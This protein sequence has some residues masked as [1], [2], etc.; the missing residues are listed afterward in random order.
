VLVSVLFTLYF[1]RKLNA[2]RKHMGP[3]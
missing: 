3:A 1:F 2:A